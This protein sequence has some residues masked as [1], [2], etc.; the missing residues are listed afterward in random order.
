MSA[1]DFT[2]EL[3]NVN[4][5]TST[6]GADKIVSLYFVKERYTPFTYLK[7]T[8]MQTI[9]NVRVREVRLYYGEKLLHCGTADSAE[10]TV[11]RNTPK[12]RLVSYGYSKQLGQDFAEPGIIETPTL[13]TIVG[14]AGITGVSCQQNTASVNY[15]YFDEKT[16]VWNAACIYTMKAYDSYPFIRGANTVRCTVPAD[17][18]TYTRPAST[19]VR[20]GRGQQLGN[21]FSDV[22]TQD[23]DRAWTYHRSS[24]FAASQNVTRKKYYPIDR[25]WVYDLNKMLK[26]HMF[27]SDRGRQFLRVTFP[28]YLG[29]DLCDKE[30]LTLVDYTGSPEISGIKL[31]VSPKGVFTELLFYF[32]SFCNT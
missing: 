24:S 5:V 6:Y 26:Y 22:Y 11:E 18:D 32:D 31:T 30:R 9:S 29:E 16:T 4:G 12:L 17:R 15:V 1:A 25:E 10:F 7:G 2:V 27:V 20:Y 8:L 13:D 23:L 28:D 19:M 14:G 21:I 3:T